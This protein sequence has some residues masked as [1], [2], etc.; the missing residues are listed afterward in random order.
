MNLVA[1]ALKRPYTFVVMAVLVLIFGIQAALETPTDIF[2]N[3]NI[4]V[5]AVVFSYNGLSAD[6][7]SGRI[8]TYFERAVTTSVD[9]V[10]HIESQSMPDYGI[11][12]IFFQPDVNINRALAEVASS[13]ET[14]LKQMPPGVTAPTM[15]S[16]DA[17]TVPILQIALS[18]NALSQAQIFDQA[19]SFIRPQ[20]T[21]VQG[22]SIPL[23]Y[24]GKVRE[25]EAD[26]NQQALHQYGISANDVTNAL[27][28]QNLITPVGTEKIGR[29]EYTVD[30]NDSPS[31]IAA[32]NNLPIKTV[33]GTVITMRDVAYVHDGSPPQTNVVH[34]DGK[35][36]V[37][38]AVQKGGNTS[39]LNIIAGIK[40]VLPQV[41]QTLPP[42]LHLT[43]VGD[44]SGYVISAVTDVLREAVIAAFLTGL[45]VLLFLGNWRSTLIITTS[46]P[47]AILASLITLSALG[48]TINIM[49]LGGLALAVGLLVDDATVTIENINS[50]L[51]QGKPLGR[52]IQDGA[53][54]IFVPAIVALMCISV[55]FVPMLNLG[56]VAGFL[57]RPL[58][59]AVIFALVASFIL[60]RTVVPVLTNY[61]LRGQPAHGHAPAPGRNP[62]TRFQ[63]RFE[64]GFE[65]V[66][67]YY[68]GLLSLG[69]GN[70]RKVIAGFLGFSALSMGLLPFLGSNFFPNVDT[71][72]IKLHI[73]A[74]IGTRIEQTTRLTDAVAAAIHH[75]IPPDQIGAIV[76]N[77]GLSIS[78]I[79]MAY[80]NSGTIGVADADM[81]ISLKPGHGP[82]AGYIRTMRSD[83]PRWFPGTT[84]SFLP[85]DIVSQILNFG[86]PAPIDVQIVGSS[87]ARDRPIADQLL[88]EI[89]K[90]PGV[91]D[92]RIQQ[93]FD[94]PT[95]Q[96]NY[97]RA[98]A[99]LVG[100]DEKTAATALVTTLAGST[101]SA[102]T[103]WL[104][105][106]TDVSY[107][108]NIETPQ[109]D[110]DTLSGLENVP[111]T[112]GMGAGPSQIVG[113]LAT[114]TR[115]PSDAVVTHY[116]VRPV[117]DIYATAQGRDL[118][119]VAQDIQAVMK[120]ARP[121]L[122][123][124]TTMVMR[125]QV[126]TMQ[127]AYTQLGAGLAFAIVLIYLLIV[128]NFQSW[129][130]PFIVVMALPTALAGIVW[131]L[132]ITGTTL[133]V[134]ALTGAIM[135]MGVATANSILVISFARERLAAGADPITAALDAGSS[136]F[137]PVA[138]TALAMIIG[139]IPT[140][141]DP[142]QNAPLGR[143][144]IGGLLF[145]TTATYFLVP[146]LF[147]AMHGR[148]AR[149]RAEPATT[150]LLSPEAS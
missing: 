2:P 104:N 9:D 70:R 140:A 122:P 75:I 23:P 117:I 97:N 16:F 21:S 95:L 27:S 82:T 24:G 34:V 3:I 119:S 69:L 130:D 137:R 32:F 102:P 40:R 96:I 121:H 86:T 12:K 57:F 44:Q 38:L 144:V 84:F 148:A 56:G 101:Q 80:N 25:V 99:G 132:F 39:I 149:K 50:H 71:G 110:I 146:I 147:G 94:E 145:A 61:L 138:M 19:T 100:L 59:E 135:C 77:I 141:V 111:L 93:A 26:L 133:S 109:P 143:A 118:G 91:A 33:N 31:T 42:G 73:R 76:D 20:L 7:M 51:E 47:L 114:V 124:G 123:R 53:D 37:L 13:S 58:A 63:R 88:A 74:P 125:G 36:A 116:N 142:G 126:A 11:I 15:L 35:N 106:K 129:L 45:M 107:P 60:S 52:A 41:E 98:M 79:N 150:V 5:V 46:I 127:A 134:P 81:M 22:A 115:E 68:R 67:Q 64:H 10:Q 48:E 103:Y 28:I 85:A 54:Q 49:T 55:A 18:S 62:F 65:V 136:R 72:Q 139:M 43:T 6:D 120:A 14:V 17:S 4:P 1:I 108:V 83:L 112:S 87:V 78:G 90:I 131:M 128:V 30:L 113:G 89:R 92:A 105:P 29:Q 66:R 8:V